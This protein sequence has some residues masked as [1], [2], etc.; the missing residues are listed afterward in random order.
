M[1][2]YPGAI[3]KPITAKRRDRMVW[4]RRMNLHVAVAEWSSLHS[5]FNVKGRPDSHFYVRKD[6]TVEQY[7]DTDFQ[8]YADL[9][10]NDATISV[11]TQ[12]G[13][14]NPNGEPWTGAQVEALAK[15]YAW[16]VRTHGIPVKM[17]SDSKIAS[18]SHGLSW[19]RL[20][21]DGNFPAL[22]SPL[23]GR[24]QRG[25]GMHYSES[26][27]KV[28]PGDAKIRQVPAVFTRALNFLEPPTPPAPA[29]PPPSSDP[30]EGIIMASWY[31]SKQA[32]E[33]RMKELVAR[34][35]FGSGYTDA[36]GDE[37]TITVAG[38]FRWAHALGRQNR[39]T[40]NAM[41]ARIIGLEAAVAAL[42]K[43]GTV[44]LDAITEAVARGIPA[45]AA[46]V[47]AADVAELLAVSVKPEEVDR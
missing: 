3:Q 14:T 33:V 46:R 8:A 5:Y 44:D 18:T 15:L 24:L 39:D 25:G 29:D 6:G 47:E 27:G 31:E 16:A 36:N 4:Y 41:N 38:G 17:A 45:G 9:D 13:V 20:G 7:V 11:E 28:C 12:G 42:A 26:A 1:A 30:L 21:V 10:G 23:A 22:P 35:T 32:F 34:A 40:L 37:V 43:D 19:H 2:K